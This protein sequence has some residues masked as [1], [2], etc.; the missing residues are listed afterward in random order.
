V[1]IKPNLSA[2]WLGR[3]NVARLLKRYDE[4]LASYDEA[5]ALAPNLAGA[6]LGR[7]NVFYGLKRYDEACAS[8][9]KA[10]ALEPRMASAWLGRG[11]AFQALERY[12]QAVASFEQ[13]LALEPDLASAWLGRG[14]VFYGLKH[15]DQAIAFYDK[16]LDLEPDLAKAWFGRGNVF[17][18]LKRYGE[19]IAFYDKALDLEP[20]LAEAWCGR[21]SGL[22]EIKR[23]DEAIASLDKA[24]ALDPDLIGAEGARLHYKMHL[25]DWTDLSADRQHLVS[26]IKKGKANAG[27][28]QL[29]AIP[30]SPE[31]QLQCARLWAAKHFMPAPNAIWH[32]ERYDHERLR[33]AYL[34]ADFRQHPVAMGM[35]GV[36]ECHDKSLFEITALSCG[37]DDDSDVR[38]R[39]Q[40]SFERFIDAQTYD[41]EQIAKLIKEL[42]I[43]IL[44]DLMGYTA[45]SRT[46]VLARRPAP[47]QVNYFGYSG[48]MGVDYIDYLIGDRTI[49]PQNQRQFYSEAVAY[50]P[51]SFLPPDDKRRIS[52]RSFSRAEIGLPE[53]GFVFCSFNNH[54]KI[55]P[56]VFA[57]W[58]RILT[59]VEGSVLWLLETN[60]TAESNLRKE[61]AA[62]GVNSE[63]L[64][65][66][67]RTPP[68]EHLAR[69]HLADLFLDTLPYNAHTTAGEALWM[70]LPVLTCRGETFAGRVAASL[71][72]TIQ[73]PELIATTI[74]GF[75]RTAIDLAANRER[76]AAI[77]RKLADTRHSTPLFDTAFFT[78]NL[79]KAYA[80]M[81]RRHRE[82]LEPEDIELQG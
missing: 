46:G 28:F 2:A 58:M 54:Y 13:T 21:G 39:L 29:L 43:D 53:H 52:D 3:G 1:G 66:A 63:R 22:G 78:K 26:S 19:A 11:N 25:C 44:V 81:H 40:A 77:K 30:S 33:I 12:D 73:M 68:A 6:W 4:A 70:G 64:I 76:L 59:Q 41:D 56:E 20:D 23:Y 75:E 10:L 60:P 50:L 16:A 45:D 61:A 74:D 32:G 7:A 36:I 71:L 5:L 35:A 27:P 79:E 24:L 57:S 48:T 8:Y 55:T 15:Y 18:R 14:N 37:P 62:R 72:T 80:T 42:E 49:I 65:F 34:S 69:H 51:N 17:S 67:A 9:D 31:D 82:G 47:I 38:R